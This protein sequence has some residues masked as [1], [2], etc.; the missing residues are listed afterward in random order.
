MFRRRIEKFEETEEIYSPSPDDHAFF[1]Y[2]RILESSIDL[3]QQRGTEEP[4]AFPL[5]FPDGGELRSICS[6]LA[7][8]NQA[9]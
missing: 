6:S 3:V 9:F 7:E 1:A 2:I 8:G 5:S 4:Y